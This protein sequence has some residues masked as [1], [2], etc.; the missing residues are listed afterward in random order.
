[1]EAEL[2]RLLQEVKML[3]YG[4]NSDRSDYSLVPVEKKGSCS[5]KHA[6]IRSIALE[7]GWQQVTLFLCIYMMN[8]ENT[9]DV[10]SVLFKYGLSEIPEAHT[11]LEINNSVVDVTGLSESAV[12]FENS[13]VLKEEIQ[14]NQIGN[15]KINFHQRF[16]ALWAD[17]T[18]YSPNGIWKIREECI[19]SLS[20]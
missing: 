8:R 5:T 9:P 2:K 1:M 15:Y 10:T 13:I 3:P 16:I 11:F 17:S 18:A 7:K 4:R 20:R 19:Q 14:P 12:P 6:Y